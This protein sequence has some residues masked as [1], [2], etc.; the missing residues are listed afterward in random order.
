MKPSV[1]ELIKYYT[2][3]K[4]KEGWGKL[5]EPCFF[6]TVRAVTQGPNSTVRAAGLAES[7]P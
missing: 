1:P 4:V 6:R 2:V 5:K 3:Y 7:N